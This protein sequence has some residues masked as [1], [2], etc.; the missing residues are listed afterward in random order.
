MFQRYL[1]GM[2]M[3]LFLGL[4]FSLTAF[5]RDWHVGD[6]DLPEQLQGL[7]QEQLDMINKVNELDPSHKNFNPALLQMFLQAQRTPPVI[8]S[9]DSTSVLPSTGADVHNDVNGVPSGIGLPPAASDGP[10]S[11]PSPVGSP[12]GATDGSDFGLFFGQFF[13]NEE[14]YEEFFWNA[15]SG[16]GGMFGDCLGPDCIPH[17]GRPGYPLGGP[18][19]GS[20]AYFDRNSA[21]FRFSMNQSYISDVLN[22]NFTALAAALSSELGGANVQHD[23]NGRVF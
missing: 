4:T 22:G 20:W 6:R 23:P 19:L 9:N 18:P 7:N 16:S 8:R 12:D 11:Y 5:A 13:M 1:R 3:L 14:D 10:T 17:I 15:M 21:D 2:F